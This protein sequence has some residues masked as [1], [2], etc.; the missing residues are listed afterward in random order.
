MP[1]EHLIQTPDQITSGWLSGALGRPDVEVESTE[2]IGTGQMSQN[3]RVRFGGGESL[4]VKLASD[5]PTSRGTGVGMGAY[6]REIA[7]YENLANRLGHSVPHCHL[8][9]YDPA[10]GWFTLLLDD[11]EGA[12]QGD[13]I[14]GCSVD[15]ARQALEA[16]AAIH[17][18]VLGD[19]ALSASDW[20]NQPNPLTQEALT[21]LW[22]A[23]R[24]RDGE[25]L[26]EW[27]DA[28]GAFEAWKAC[29]AGR[30]C[31]YSAL[32]HDRLRRKGGLQW[33]GERLYTDGVF[34]TDPAFAETYGQDLSR[35]R[36][37][38][39]RSTARRRLAAAPS[40]TP[41]TTTRRPGRRA[42][43]SRSC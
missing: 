31:D 7:F 3:F 19:L 37:R 35:A 10:E 34:N 6:Y 33:G 20:V 25:P 41:P 5:D 36:P 42:T 13:Q 39:S 22:P 12:V 32:S 40:C 30:P 21:A 43:R 28:H 8:A 27:D 18:P 9:V 14:A 29:F 26:N 23:F 16:L 38:A 15:Q 17:A 4:V 24:D 11:V 1:P 2:R